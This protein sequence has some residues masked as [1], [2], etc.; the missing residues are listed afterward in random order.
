MALSLVKGQPSQQTD[1]RGIWVHFLDHFKRYY[2]FV[3][4][5]IYVVT[6]FIT[7]PISSFRENVFWRQQNET[8]EARMSARTLL[9]PDW[10]LLKGRGGL[11]NGSAK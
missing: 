2:Y 11:A 4:Q 10:E 9:G 7:A 6:E 3:L 8:S 1:Q 5:A